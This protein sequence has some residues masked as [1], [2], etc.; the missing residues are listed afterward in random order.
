MAAYKIGLLTVYGGDGVGYVGGSVKEGLVYNNCRE[1]ENIFL[2]PCRKKIHI[3][4]MFPEGCTNSK[5][6]Y[7]ICKVDPPPSGAPWTMFLWLRD[8]QFWHSDLTN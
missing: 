6:L 7:S 2:Y 1:D 4:H 5:C 8:L 3:N